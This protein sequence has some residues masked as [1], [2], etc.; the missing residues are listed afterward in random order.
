MHRVALALEK[1]I[2][3]FQER[4]G[5]IDLSESS[6]EKNTGTLSSN[7]P[8]KYVTQ[9]A[10]GNVRTKKRSVLF[11]MKLELSIIKWFIRGQY[12]LSS[13]MLH[14][15]SSKACSKFF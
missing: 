15:N 3:A 14:K 1:Q 8:L 11:V 5:L 4:R 9:S 7:S 12:I 13:V 6:S 2:K 10:I